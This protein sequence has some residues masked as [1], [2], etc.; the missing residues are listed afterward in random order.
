MNLIETVRNIFESNAARTFIFESQTERQFSYADFHNMAIQAATLLKS[1]N[2]QRH[3]RVALLLNN[4]VEFAALYFGCL[5][6]GAVAM[7]VNPALHVIEI[8]FIL[9]HSGQQLIVYAPSTKIILEEINIHHCMSLG[10]IPCNES[11]MSSQGTDWS[12]FT[13]VEA[14]SSEDTIWKPLKG[15]RDDDLFS[16]HFTSGTTSLP[17]GVPH[18][19]NALLR[20]AFAFNNEFGVTSD[21]RFLHV[22]PMSYMA[23]FLN[24]LLCPFMAEGSVVL[25]RQFDAASSLRFWGP[26][27]KYGVDTF[28][29]T[30]TMLAVLSRIDRGKEG[31]EY[32]RERVKNVF[33]GTAPLPF[34][35]KDEFEKK[36][37][38]E[39][40]ESYGLSELLFVSANSGRHPRVKGSVGQILPDIEVTVKSENG[41]LLQAG[42]DGEIWIKTPFATPGYLADG[43]KQAQDGL[44]AGWFP[45]GDIGYRDERGNLFITARKKDLIIRGGFNIS[46]RAVEEVIMTHPAVQDVCVVGL[47]HDFYGEE[48]VA[49]VCLKDGHT[50]SA[51]QPSLE[52]LCRQELSTNAIPTRFMSME[53]FPLSTTG[54]IQKH[55]IRSMLQGN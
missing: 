29:M 25:S 49:V 42:K 8:E 12:M 53:N 20:N 45:T 5:F 52:A 28:W 10:I 24:T 46:P 22:L 43:E 39:V 2:I 37:S 1:K 16:I 48:V 55:E 21:S 33:V 15:I 13:E 7:P 36:Y 19:I 54:K 23:G 50:L 9:S 44:K 3:D 18:R 14:S 34:K 11:D 47:S 35:T 27:I 31:L 51:E 41:E 26:A 38:V 32:C 40:Y 30:P 6:S 17:K 4:S